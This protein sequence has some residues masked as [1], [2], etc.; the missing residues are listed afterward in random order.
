MHFDSSLVWLAMQVVPN[1]CQGSGKG[2][3]D[4]V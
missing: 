1:K 2:G 4:L 3:T